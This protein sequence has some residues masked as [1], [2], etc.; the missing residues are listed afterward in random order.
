L[1]NITKRDNGKWQAK[2]RRKGW[3]DQSKTFQTLEAAQQWARATEREM[4][5]GAFINRSDAER[6]TFAEACNRFALEL[7]VKHCGQGVHKLTLESDKH[8]VMADIKQAIGNADLKKELL[9][10]LKKAAS[11]L[12]RIAALKETFG[13]YS[14]AS[15]SPALLASYRDTRLAYLSP[16]TV[17]HE[18]NMCSRIFKRCQLDWGIALPQ[19]VPTAAVRKPVVNNERDRRLEPGEWEWLK[20]A[21]AECKS[22]YPLAAVEFDLETAARQSEVASLVIEEVDLKRRTA[23]LRGIDG[24]PT[25]NGD[26]YRDV[27]LSSRAVAV[28]SALP[29]ALKGKVFKNSQEALK[30]SYARA[31][32]RARKRYLDHKITETLIHQHGYTEDMAAAEIRAITYKK[33]TPAP[34]TLKIKEEL[35]TTDTFLVDLHFHDLR[36]EATSRLA[37]HLQMHELMKVTGHTS[38][39]MLA[40]YYHPRASDLAKKL[41]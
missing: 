41:A 1:A 32:L 3:P 21:L 26:P 12:S 9:P 19:G 27:P 20:P 24:G 22:P 17:K 18:L 10:G 6:M 39:A 35:E 4:D 15:I 30:Q 2:I 34:L 37:E 16:Q 33:K 28:L 8:T 38:S 5:I 40:R 29:R 31:V 11:D 23:R 14:L 7:L 13:A 25:K 36:H